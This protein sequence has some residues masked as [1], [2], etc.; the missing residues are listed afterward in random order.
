MRPV[1]IF[2]AVALAL[3]AGTDAARA[4]RPPDSSHY[5]SDNEIAL[6]LAQNKPQPY[7]MNYAD[8]AAQTLGVKD[9]RWEAF[10]TRSRDPLMPSLRG[11]IMDGAA[12]L[13]LQWHPGG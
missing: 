3:G 2:L 1:W 5:P 6:K 10:A 9:G 8:E 11:G 4:F 7:P 12:M 13:R